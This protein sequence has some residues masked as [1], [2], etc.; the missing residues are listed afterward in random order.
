[1]C[2]P[3]THVSA[4]GH[5]SKMKNKIQ[6]LWSLSFFILAVFCYAL[7]ASSQDDDPIIITAVQI[8]GESADDDFIEL[9]NP[10]CDPVDLSGWKLLKKTKTGSISS[11]G[12]LDKKIPAKGYYLWENNK[13]HTIGEPDHTTKTYYLADDYSIALVDK[14]GDQIDAL[15]WGASPDPFPDALAYPDN[16]A[17]SEALRRDPEDD[18]LSLKKNY[19]PKNSSDI[20]QDELDVCPV[21]TYSDQIIIN[22]LFPAPAEGQEEFIELYNPTDEEQDLSGW[23]LRDDSKSGKYVFPKDSA[24]KS[25]DYLTVYKK[26]FGFALNNSGGE[27]VLLF[28]PTE[29]EIARAEYKTAKTGY[30]YAFDGAGWHW[31]SQPTPGEE[32]QF[33]ELLSGKIKKDSTV[34]SGVYAAFEAKVGKKVKKVVWD[35]GDGHKSYL[36]KTKH[37]YAKSGTY[38]ATLKFTGDGEENVIKFTVKVK[39]FG[40]PKI[41]LAALVPNPAGKDTENE[42]IEITNQTKK[43]INLKGWSVAT[44]WKNLYNHPIRDNFIIAGGE[45]KKLTRK[46][47]A[48]ALG[49]VKAKIELRYPN[50][51]AADKLKYD[52]EKK[53]AAENAVYRKDGKDWKWILAPEP[54]KT[55]LG[56]GFKP[57]PTE[58]V[59]TPAEPVSTEPEKIDVDLSLLGGAS[60]NPDWKTRQNN[61]VGIILAGTDINQEKFRGQVL[62]ASIG[63]TDHPRPKT[64]IG[65]NLKPVTISAII[66]N[67]WRLVNARLNY[68]L[69]HARQD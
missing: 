5:I 25:E 15:A 17:P 59:P 52:L 42:W 27:K 31:T 29:K 24:I 38:H 10:S 37:K 63:I 11:L 69:D 23:I 33:D 22:E 13:N 12:T 56:T 14:S 2:P 65:T 57:V 4:H 36:K 61:Q 47:C 20:D 3:V 39:S 32:N 7:P 55:S 21:K 34:Y 40:Q 62:G 60:R 18:A 1:M 68:L 6:P 67:L 8:A 58:P 49:N 19:S 51:K 46:I 30:G 45:T 16:P 44:G 41:R 64:T 26:D 35:F 54:E 53:A 9:Y 28:D 66:D 48:F 43:S 50:G